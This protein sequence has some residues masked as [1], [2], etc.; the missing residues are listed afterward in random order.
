MS[1]KLG[2]Q[3]EFQVGVGKSPENCHLSR[4]QESSR[5]PSS[6]PDRGAVGVPGAGATGGWAS[7]R[8]RC[9]LRGEDQRPRLEP[10]SSPQKGPGE[11]RRN[12]TGTKEGQSERKEGNQGRKIS[13]RRRCVEEEG[14]ATCV[15]RV[16]RPRGLSPG[17]VQKGGTGNP[18]V[19]LS[20]G[21]RRIRNSH[22]R[23][24]WL[25]F[26]LI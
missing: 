5:G 11:N 3:R 24:L 1:G 22:D 19:S 13:E 25:R 6:H 18:A 17:S 4:L 26:L 23:L 15:Q 10:R 21:M 8:N 16:T 14:A 7:L 2:W 12:S 20:E 9:R